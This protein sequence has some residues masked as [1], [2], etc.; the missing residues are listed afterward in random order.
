M[1][2]KAFT[3]STTVTT[4]RFGVEVD[5]WEGELSHEKNLLNRTKI[6]LV[7]FRD[8][9]TVER[10]SDASDEKVLIGKKLIDTPGRYGVSTIISL[11]YPD[12]IKK[13]GQDIGD[14]IWAAVEK[15]DR[16]RSD[17]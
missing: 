8:K 3:S 17:E 14:K 13:Y 2:E 11:T 16:I 6:R 4:E 10:A 5:T 1:S 15:F 9:A 7:S 12:L